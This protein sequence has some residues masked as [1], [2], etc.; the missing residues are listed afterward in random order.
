MNKKKLSRKEREFLLEHGSLQSDV[1]KESTLPYNNTLIRYEDIEQESTNHAV[2]PELELEQEWD[3]PSP[4][5][6]LL[7]SLKHGS[8]D[9]DESQISQSDDENDNFDDESHYSLSNDEAESSNFDDQSQCSQSDD[10]NDENQSNHSND[11]SVHVDVQSESGHSNNESDNESDNETDSDD[12]TMHEQDIFD[13]QFNQ[14]LIP[15]SNKQLK[16]TQSEVLGNIVHSS[17]IS[18]DKTVAND[19]PKYVCCYCDF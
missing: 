5:S 6:Q 18:M 13:T 3:K 16:A 10:E 11:E 15:N 19:P 9:D 14:P 4:F 7:Q 1:L 12:E 8:N 17:F 2:E